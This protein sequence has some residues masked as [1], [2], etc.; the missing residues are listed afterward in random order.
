MVGCSANSLLFHSFHYLLLRIN[1]KCV[2]TTA[3][4]IG[5]AVKTR[6]IWDWLL[7]YWIFRIPNRFFSSCKFE[8][9]INTR[10]VRNEIYFGSDSEW[11]GKKLRL[12]SPEGFSV[13]MTENRAERHAREIFYLVDELFVGYFSC[14]TV[15]S[16]RFLLIVVAINH[17]SY[18]CSL[19]NW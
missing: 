17:V 9:M 4:S 11:R 8:V 6:R 14:S 1:V 3:I 7:K 16:S 12:W 19:P 15:T 5:Q 10:G 13:F 2:T 18:H